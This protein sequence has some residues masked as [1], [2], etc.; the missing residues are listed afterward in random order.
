MTE[1]TVP[2]GKTSDPLD[3]TVWNLALRVASGSV[4]TV[5]LLL[6]AG[7][8][9]LLTAWLIAIAGG[10]AWF[11]AV[12]MLLK[13]TKLPRFW[14]VCTGLA[15]LILLIAGG[16][17]AGYVIAL[18]LSF[19]FL[20]FRTY[21]P[22]RHLT[23]SRRGRVGLVAVACILLLP[24]GVGDVQITGWFSGIGRHLANYALWSLRIFWILSAINLFLR[25]RL[26]FLRLK[27]K[28]VVMSLFLAVVPM[29]LVGVFGAATFFG[30]VGIDRAT[31]GRAVLTRWIDEGLPEVQP[32]ESR[33]RFRAEITAGGVERLTGV[34]PLWFEDFATIIC[35][36]AG[37]DTAA[38]RR[39]IMADLEEAGE[40][41]R[42]IV[43]TAVGDSLRAVA[44]RILQERLAGMWTPSDTTALLREGGELWRIRIAGTGT[45]L[46]QI[47]G[48][49]VM[50][51]VLGRL[52]GM[53]HTH[54]NIT[55][56]G[57]SG[58]IQVGRSGLII[59]AGSETDSV[60]TALRIEG[61]YGPWEVGAG[62]ARTG[63]FWKREIYLGAA[64]L[65]VLVVGSGGFLLDDTLLT[66]QGTLSG[67]FWDVVAGE[68][69]F[70]QFLGGMLI[71]IAVIFLLIVLT[72]YFL[73]VRITAGITSAVRALHVGTKRIAEGDLDHHIG[74]P[75]LDEFGDLASSFN[76]M[77]AA[78][79]RGR[80][81][82][83]ARERLERELEM[84]RSIQERLMPDEM[85]SIPG[86]EVAARS[87]PTR[88]V[89]GD[90]FD[91][92]DLRENLLGVAVG[93]VSGKG[94]PAALL[95]A[96]LQAALQGQVI[97]P[98]TVAQ[99]V[100]RVNDLLV[101]SSEVGMFATFFYGVLDRVAASFTYCNAGHNPVILLRGD[102]SLEW[103]T[104]GGIVLG[105]MADQMYME[106]TVQLEPGDV[107][108][109][110]SDGITEAEG[111]LPV[112]SEAAVTAE[113]EEGGQPAAAVGSAAD[114]A[115]EGEAAPAP[116]SVDD[117]D[118]E[119]DE[120]ED[121]EYEPNFYGEERL[122]EAVRASA[123][124]SAVEIRDAI[125]S[126]VTQF[127][128]GIPQSDDI[129]I[130]VL[131]RLAE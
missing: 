63:P 89:G 17:A 43:E 45:G 114:P 7:R 15:A 90:Y 117:E 126:E 118:E 66:V 13:D 79:K 127:T 58:D 81:E 105:M 53:L 93:D 37:V 54:V 65:K 27:P 82:A 50:P 108:V 25:M 40:R 52:A 34:T 18:V 84:A 60:G 120:D 78:V 72:A 56:P 57:E 119:P 35:K 106:E 86:F 96:N 70:S 12:R 33:P 3:T 23:G 21:R 94:V 80:E 100:G 42:A 88:Y 24:A 48:E 6:L 99:V 64:L 97:H 29:V 36:P 104:E 38:L 46:M 10:W 85:P 109:L 75:N 49:Q 103:L 122:V 20:L 5:V 31:R 39:E 98:S 102:G 92:V 101:R 113:M 71:S 30:A 129:T 131:K 1:E 2:A 4:A 111:P 14:A 107:L 61:R 69:E 8:G 83:V 110:Y 95:M 130:V 32:G 121:F 68:S 9:H 73:G 112:E 22:Y 125:L 51:D 74:I 87:V 59:T 11:E 16:N 128:E 115:P 28:L 123:R 41:F 91:F 47:E 76:E 55:A 26:H 67:L 77:A 116:V 44:E 62:E 19:I 124:L